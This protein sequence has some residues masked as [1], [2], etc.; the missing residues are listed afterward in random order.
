MQGCYQGAYCQNPWLLWVARWHD[1]ALTAL[2]KL[3]QRLSGSWYHEYKHKHEQPH[4]SIFPQGVAKRKLVKF[5]HMRRVKEARSQQIAEEGK[6]NVNH[7][8]DRLCHT[9]GLAERLSVLAKSENRNQD[10]A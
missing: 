5:E 4:N 7:K 9:H 8:D 10:L 1:P 6:Y 2:L 3:F